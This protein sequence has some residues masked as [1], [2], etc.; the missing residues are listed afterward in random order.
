VRGIPSLLLLGIAWSS[1]PVAAQQPVPDDEPPPNDATEAD[2]NTDD[3]LTLRGR[4][5]GDYRLRSTA[6]SEIPLTPFP[7]DAT[8]E[9]A[10]LGQRFFV[11]QWLRIAGEIELVELIR[12]VGEIDV[13]DGV[14]VG[15]LTNGVSWAAQ[16]RDDVSAIAGFDPRALHLDWSAPFG[17]VLVGLTP[18]HWGLG[19]LLNDGAHWPRF[20]D[21]RFGD[22][23]LRVGADIEPTGGDGPLS[24]LAAV[25]LV[26][27][28][29][30]AQLA[31]GDDAVRGSLGA[32]FET[33]D[34]TVGLL[35]M[36]RA[37]RS[38]SETGPVPL[39]EREDHIAID[40]FARVR[41]PDPSGGA[42]TLSAEAAY[43]HGTSTADRP[44]GAESSD[45][46]ELLVAGVLART[47][48]LLDVEI[49]LG[50][51]SGDAVPDDGETSRAAMHPDHRIGLLLFPELLAW[52]TARS[53]TLA[54][55]GIGLARP[56]AGNA[57]VPTNG[58]VAG[59]A[60]VFPTVGIRPMDGVELRVGALW[61]VATADLVDPW[62]YRVTSRA[63]SYRG[64]DPRSRDLGLEIDASLL[65]GAP[66]AKGVELLGGL[67]GAVLIP[68]HAF[69]DEHGNALGPL[70]L[71]RVRGGLRF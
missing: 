8:G 31:R 13:F 60:Y 26:Y 23:A 34:V 36:L 1:A 35:G 52:Q 42:I 6:M 19:I 24:F 70:G 63:R 40:G 45:V 16:P 4:I 48:P 65:L 27:T 39:E 50:W 5:T 15:E 58:S 17:S 61:A 68:G 69:D 56:P 7:D 71:L 38:T 30:R 47:S 25:D 43:V 37:Q 51:T 11:H 55:S 2:R 46:R 22:V 3:S 53:A 62:R 57:R 9:S 64:A 67:E 28:D 66:L 59:A 54:G 44:F 12:L 32:M 29:P 18:V 14:L 49:A 41:L 10:T 20:G 33:D 21:Y